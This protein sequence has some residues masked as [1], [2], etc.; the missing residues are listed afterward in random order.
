MYLDC[1]A[2]SP[3]H[4]LRSLRL[5]WNLKI[6]FSSV[7]P[8]AEKT[9]HPLPFKMEEDDLNRLNCQPQQNCTF[10]N[11]DQSFNYKGTPPVLHIVSLQFKSE[12]Y[13]Q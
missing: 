5:R 11:S 10:Y 7:I 13:K 8:Y 4:T 3:L 9:L 6:G 2:N 1:P 12:N